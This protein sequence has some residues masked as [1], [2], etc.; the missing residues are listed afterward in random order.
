MPL[1]SILGPHA[2]YCLLTTI[3]CW[4][5]IA[6]MACLKRKPYNYILYTTTWLCLRNDWGFFFQVMLPEHSAF[7][8]SISQIRVV[9]SSFT[10]LRQNIRR[11]SS[12]LWLTDWSTFQVLLLLGDYTHKSS[13][14]VKHKEVVSIQLLSNEQLQKLQS[15]TIILYYSYMVL[16]LPLPALQKMLKSRAKIDNDGTI[17]TTIFFWHFKR[18]I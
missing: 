12:G 4:K 14:R 17:K 10:I 13:N 9:S 7:D 8:Q 1:L 5:A 15:T 18:R 3:C 16:V 11:D 2:I 6:S